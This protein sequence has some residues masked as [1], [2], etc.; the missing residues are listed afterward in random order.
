MMEAIKFEYTVS[1][2]DFTSAGQASTD[3]KRKLKV[4][5]VDSK[6][7]RNINIA[8]YEGEI[9]L[10]IHAGG[11]DITVLVYPEKVEMYLDDEGPGIENIELALTEGYSGASDAVRSLGF[12]AGMGL[13]N[14]KK[15]ADEFYIESEVGKGTHIK[16]VV[17]LQ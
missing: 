16:M 11:G 3:L 2:D 9:N 10:A 7:L 5:G 17:Y 4:M 13:P 15:Y 12:G 8:L 1:G 14:M 6:S